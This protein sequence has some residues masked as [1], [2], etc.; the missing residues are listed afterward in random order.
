MLAVGYVITR[1]A[2]FATA[3]ALVDTVTKLVLTRARKRPSPQKS[4]RQAVS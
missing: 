2:V 1:S 4:P 3:I